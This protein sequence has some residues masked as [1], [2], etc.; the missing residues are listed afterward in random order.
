LSTSFIVCKIIYNVSIYKKYNRIAKR[1]CAFSEA[2]H[3]FVSLQVNKHYYFIKD[4]GISANRYYLEQCFQK[5]IDEY[6]KNAKI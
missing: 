5:Q 2:N 4:N 1:I 6:N 3:C